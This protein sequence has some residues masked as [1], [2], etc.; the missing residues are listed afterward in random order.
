MTEWNRKLFA[1]VEWVN[2]SISCSLS[3]KSLLERLPRSSRSRQI[4]LYG[5]TGFYTGRYLSLRLHKLPYGSVDF[6]IAPDL[7]MRP[8]IFSYGA[9]SFYLGL[10]PSL[11]PRIL[12]YSATRFHTAQYPSL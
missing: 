4:L 8:Q 1:T 12:P 9:R 5:L 10:Y 2:P 7:S 3:S 6:Y 11:S